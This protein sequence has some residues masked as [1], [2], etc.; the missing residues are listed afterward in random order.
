MVARPVRFRT[1]A[2]DATGEST[3][4]VMM[5]VPEVETAH[6][7]ASLLAKDMATWS[8]TRLSP[9]AALLPELDTINA[10]V[11]ELVRNDGIAAGAERTFV[12]NVVGPRVTCKPNPDRVG[13]GKSPEWAAEWSAHVESLF[14]SFTDT[15]WFD[16]GLRHDF[17]TSTRLQARMLAATG[18]AVALPLWRRNTGSRWFTCLRLIDP[19]R[20]CNPQGRTDGYGLDGRMIRGGIELDDDGAAVAYHIRKT[21]PGDYGIAGL[22]RFGD[23]PNQRLPASVFSGSGFGPDEWERVPAYQEWGRRRVLHLYDP[24]RVGQTRGKAVIASVARQFKMVNHY[25][26]EELRLAVLNSLVFAALE[27]PMDQASIVETFS[28]SDRPF[29][30]YQ[31]ALAEWRIQMKGGAMIPLPPGTSMKPF[32]T[33]RANTALDPF[34]TVMLRSISAGLNMPYELL[35]KDFSK[36]NYSSARAALIEAWRYFGSVR[37]M[38]VDRWCALIYD[39]WFEE[40]VQRGLIPDCTPAD[41]YANQIAW[42]RAKWIF[43]GRGWVDPLKE[44]KA[45]TERLGSGIT[46]LADECGEQG[47]DWREQLEQRGR[48]NALADQLGLPRPHAAKAPPSGHN[49]GPPLDDPDDKEAEEEAKAA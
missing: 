48:E 39:M 49:G 44:A 18:E 11:D 20:L 28:G 46:T 26:R 10:R 30:A 15:D 37:Q 24:E 3:R 5:A 2:G 19:A 14:R 7:A 41:Y 6:H 22:A 36:T 1:K 8:A 12:D 25:L 43:A 33:G 45:A 35:L 13:L 40:A 47:H 31:A 34:V 16:I 38:V 23:Q 42:T 29:D 4:P 32:S 9:D 21:H 17:H 27:T